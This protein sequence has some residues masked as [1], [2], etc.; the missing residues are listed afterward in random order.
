[1]RQQ[2]FIAGEVNTFLKSNGFSPHEIIDLCDL[3]IAALGPSRVKLVS[4]GQLRPGVNG[5]FLLNGH[6]LLRAGMSKIMT[7]EV[8][9]HEFGH[10][11]LRH[12]TIRT[13]QCET[14]ADMAGSYLLMP[15]HAFAA[16]RYEL[17]DNVRWLARMFR[18]RPDLVVERIEER[19]AQAH[20]VSGAPCDSALCGVSTW[21]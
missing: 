16:A 9:A 1:M 4:D 5:A 2:I 6:I 20:R 13:E 21:A 18:V 14:Q 12:H 8:L 17:N 7:R 3:A 15:N 10:L 11:L 19:A